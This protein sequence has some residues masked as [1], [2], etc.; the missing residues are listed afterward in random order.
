MKKRGLTLTLILAQTLMGY[1]SA[2]A[3]FCS[4]TMCWHVDVSHWTDMNTLRIYFKIISR[5][6]ESNYEI[7]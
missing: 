6:L 5:S 2:I 7:K 1:E 3:P 4:L